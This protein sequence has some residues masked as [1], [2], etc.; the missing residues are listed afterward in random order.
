MLKRVK[1][2][3][4]CQII[5]N[6]LML[7]MMILIFIHPTDKYYDFYWFIIGI[8]FLG[9]LAFVMK[10]CKRGVNVENKKVRIRK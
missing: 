6:I 2:L 8:N 4:L 1:Y 10:W 5:C 9:N 7:V 3:N